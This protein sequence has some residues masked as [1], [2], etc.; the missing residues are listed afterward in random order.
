[1]AVKLNTNNPKTPQITTGARYTEPRL[2]DYDGDLTKQ[3]FIIYYIWNT[4]K[5]AKVRKRLLVDGKTAVI[6]RATAKKDIDEITEYLRAGYTVG[7]VKQ[8]VQGEINI[9]TITF[10]KAVEHAIEK[11]SL[12]I[13][14]NT[15]KSYHTFR[16]VFTEWCRVKNY[17]DLLLKEATV[18]VVHKFFDYL[19][20]VRQIENKTYNNYLGYLTTIFNWYIDREYL[21]KNPC[22][23]V[24]K[25]PVESGGHTPYSNEQVKMIKK[26]IERKGDKQLLLFIQFIYY[27]LVRPGEFR[28]CFKINV[29]G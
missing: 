14:D 28:S 5:N 24:D 26:L 4:D 21:E 18:A 2:V 23:K 10:Y 11:K 15:L 8:P 27:T 7:T 6:R 16:R 1:M 19:K 3:W 9:H 25:L 12:S 20:S 29:V 13:K 17:T 22:N